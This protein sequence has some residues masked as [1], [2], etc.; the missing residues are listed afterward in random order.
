MSLKVFYHKRNDDL[1]NCFNL[2]LKTN[3]DVKND[4]PCLF[5]KRF[6]IWKKLLIID[7]II[8]RCHR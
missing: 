8:S 3:V 1:F 2:S 4:R 6:K 5:S 7:A